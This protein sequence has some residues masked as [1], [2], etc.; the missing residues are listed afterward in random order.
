MKRTLL[1]ALAVSGICALAIDGAAAQE[2]ATAKTRV[3]MVQAYCTTGPCDTNFTFQS[4]SALVNRLKQPK[5]YSK[6]KIGRVRILGLEAT[7]ASV[8]LPAALE[9]ELQVRMIYDTVDPDGDCPDLGS[10]T[11]ETLATSSMS[12]KPNSSGR[13][14]CGGD[15]LVPLGLFDARCTDVRVFMHDFDIDVYE[16]GGVGVDTARVATQGLSVFGVEPDC[17]S[18]GSGCP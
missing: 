13:A 10:D 14:T 6:R 7:T 16:F 11:V 17:S 9:A 3:R 8:I 18:G 12:C 2:V 15:L 1:G 5:P 4:G